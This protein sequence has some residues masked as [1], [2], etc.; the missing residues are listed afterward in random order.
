MVKKKATKKKVAKKAPTKKKVAK[1]PAKKPTK[2]KVSSRKATAKPVAKP[3]KKK[4]CGDGLKALGLV[5]NIIILPGL[6]TLIGGGKKRRTEGTI[7]LIVSVIAWALITTAI[8]SI[9]NIVA[10]LVGV[11]LLFIMWIWGIV[12]MARSFSD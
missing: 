4:T 2:K 12:S 8:F 9:I 3:V 1:K 5:L 6:G 7:Q 10:L 11:I